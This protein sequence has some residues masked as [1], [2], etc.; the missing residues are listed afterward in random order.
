MNARNAIA[1]TEI[2]PLPVG[3][4]LVDQIDRLIAHLD[5]EHARRDQALD[6]AY[7]G[8]ATELR[9]IE[10]E[11]AAT[12]RW[13]ALRPALTALRRK[14][15]LA[16]LEVPA[17]VLLGFALVLWLFSWEWLGSTGV[18][19]VIA[20]AATFGGAVALRRYRLHGVRERLNAKLMRYVG[21]ND[22]EAFPFQF[23]LLF[24]YP[25]AL[26]GLGEMTFVNIDEPVAGSHAILLCDRQAANV[27]WITRGTNG[28]R[29]QVDSGMPLVPAGMPVGDRFD[30]L[31]ARA[32]ALRE[33]VLQRDAARAA[34]QASC[35]RKDVLVERWADIVLPEDTKAAL[36][37]ALVHFAYGDAAAPRGILL[38]GPPGTGKS[39]VAQVFADSVDAAFFKCSVAEL[40]GRHIGESASNVRALWAQARERAPAIIFIDECEGSFPARGSD[41]GD[42]FTNEVVQ[43]FLTEWDGIGGE[44]HVLVIGAT[45]RPALLDDAIVS[46]FTDV[47]ELL[48]PSAEGR[49]ELV[50]AVARAV[51]LPS[52]PPEDAIPLFAGMSGREV[53][54]ALQHAMRLAAPATPTITHFRDATAKTRGKTA[55]RT[56]EDARWERLVLPEAII[57]E[58]KVMTRMVRE[59]EALRQKGIPVP[60]ALLLYGP[61]GTGKTQIARTFANESGVGFIARST[62]ELKGQYLGQAASR[63]AQSFEAARAN[64]P[65]I[66]F[67]DEIDALTVARGGDAGDALQAEALTQLLQEMDGVRARPGFVFVMA[68]TNRLDAIDAAVRSRFQKQIEIGLPDAAGRVALLRTLLAGRPASGDLNLAALAAQTEGYSGRELNELVA[69]AFQ[70]AVFRTLEA[71]SAASET[72]L[73]AADLVVARGGER[74]MSSSL[75]EGA[76]H[77]ES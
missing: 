52:L 22:G 73:Q 47:I 67:I 70:H 32:Q 46:R 11:L 43:T 62:A 3:T 35:L 45:N 13:G 15:R 77:A 25:D 69:S 1:T 16:A 34:T 29:L 19:L 21:R 38:E 64:S 51:N 27:A 5:G 57:R 75:P 53:R 49:H 40:K 31:V 33:K 20:I 2:P 9:A 65:S 60:R 37:T 39:L 44:S 50:R 6:I 7:E 24:D 74:M 36:M 58:F 41:Q 18:A 54:N 10:R 56:D 61:P 72:V 48:P 55:T 23:E 17:A 8:I 59:A 71:G 66:L 26:P 42:T 63:I 4:A 30:A 12:L 76:I 28:W 14:L 68:A